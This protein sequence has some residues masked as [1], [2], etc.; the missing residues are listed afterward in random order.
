M[1]TQRLRIFDVQW[2]YLS[3]KLPVKRMKYDISAVQQPFYYDTLIAKKS[4]D[5]ISKNNANMF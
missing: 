5:S 1:Y 2:H 3:L 4:R